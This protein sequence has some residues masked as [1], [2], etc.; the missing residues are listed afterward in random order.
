MRTAA[1]SAALAVL[2]GIV[3]CDQPVPD[4][5]LQGA[6][7]CTDA[8][9]ATEQYF[10]DVMLPEFFDPYCLYCH[11]AGLQGS[12]RHGALVGVNFDTLDATKDVDNAL[13]WD[14]VRIREMPPLGRT[15]STNELNLL[16]DWLDCT[17]V[18]LDDECP[19]DTLGFADVAPIFQEH[20]TSCHNSGLSEAD[21]NGAPV[22]ADWDDAEGVRDFVPAVGG[23]DGLLRLWSRVVTDQ[24]P[25]PTSA[26][27][28]TSAQKEVLYDW[29]SC[30]APD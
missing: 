20:C 4:R 17:D 9:I 26:P 6:G 19:D 8:T 22:G 5:G 27:R 3:G 21:R 18:T 24:M 13:I 11:T 23:P 29:L 7:A 28:V 25:L 10:Q 30:G 16:L 14:R 15:P 2:I 12:D 1:L